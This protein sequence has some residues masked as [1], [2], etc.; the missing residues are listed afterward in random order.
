[1]PTRRGPA[2]RAIVKALNADL[3]QAA[4]ERGKE[5]AWT[6]RDRKTVAMIADLADIRSDLMARYIDCTDMKA[7]TNASTE[8][9]QLST[10]IGTLSD[11]LKI[12]APQPKTITQVKNSRAA[13]IRWDRAR[14]QGAL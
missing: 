6:E 5:L 12:D 2:A 7:A 9:R 4:Q 14:A 10:T 11:R 1:M 3:K 8:I 13:N